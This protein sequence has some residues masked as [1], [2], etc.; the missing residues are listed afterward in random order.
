[1]KPDYQSFRFWA[2]AFLQVVGGLAASGVISCP[3]TGCSPGM[4]AAVQV[5]GF[6]TMLGSYLGWTAGKAYVQANADTTPPNPVS[7]AAPT[8]APVLPEAAALAADL[9]KS[10]HATDPDGATLPPGVTADQMAQ[11]VALLPVAIEHLK[12]LLPKPA[13][14]TPPMRGD[15]IRP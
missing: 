1:M 10:Q 12:T 7:V 11:L 6:L 13:A 5:V 15:G 3:A 4:Q 2:M 14:T 9:D 8:P